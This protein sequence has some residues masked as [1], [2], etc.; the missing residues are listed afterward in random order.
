MS[1]GILSQSVAFSEFFLEG[2]AVKAE[3]MKGY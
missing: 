3:L 1:A 2:F